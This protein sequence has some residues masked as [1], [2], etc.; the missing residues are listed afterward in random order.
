MTRALLALLFFGPLAPPAAAGPGDG[1]HDPPE[2]VTRAAAEAFADLAGRALAEGDTAGAEA[3]LGAALAGDWQSPEALA[4]LGEV[5][6]AR[7]QTGAA[8][9][10]LERAARLAPTDPAIG[11]AR[12]EAY[13]AAG[14]A[15][16][17]APGPLVAARV[18]SA[19]AGA[20]L[21]VALALALY[22][23]VA[24]LG[25]AWWRARRAAPPEASGEA[26]RGG[27]SADP[28][29][30][31]APEHASGAAQKRTRALG[32]TLAALGPLALLALL[33]AATALWDAGRPR[34]VAL[35]GVDLLARPAPEAPPVGSVREGE[36]V[37]VR[38]SQGEWRLVDLGETEGWAPARAVPD[39]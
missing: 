4:L 3:A 29:R 1:A 9:L 32:W 39:L 19:R 6:L 2:A 38:E 14:Q 16:P 26:P 8:V 21:L 18:A 13:A 15:P 35:A 34:A 33:L 10:A 28:L 24:A 23:G 11:R 36:V 31:D 25:L 12:R 5:R 27:G 20:G 30:S 17:V 22:L 37:R 7:G